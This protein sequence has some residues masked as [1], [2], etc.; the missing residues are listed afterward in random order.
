VCSTEYLTTVLPTFKSWTVHERIFYVRTIVNS[1]WN[2]YHSTTPY[3]FY[4]PCTRS[5]RVDNVCYYLEH[6]RQTAKATYMPKNRLR[7]SD[8]TRN[9]EIFLKYVRR[10][11]SRRAYS[12][13]SV[14]GGNWELY[15][16]FVQP[17]W[18]NGQLVLMMWQGTIAASPTHNSGF[19][20]SAVWHQRWFDLRNITGC[21]ISITP[22]SLSS[23]LF[24][25]TR[26]PL[27]KYYGDGLV[28]YRCYLFVYCFLY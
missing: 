27:G 3:F 1:L 16:D 9:R 26:I 23:S 20:P 11:T 4:P 6:Q 22:S 13:S 5:P 24:R 10:K 7:Y 12:G 2:I 17:R 21:H 15:H 18:C 8:C 19:Q 28:F 14:G 25:D